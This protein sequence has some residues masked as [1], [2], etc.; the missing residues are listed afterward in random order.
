MASIAQLI[1]YAISRA[2]AREETGGGLHEQ[3]RGFRQV[4]LHDLDNEKF[5]DMYAQTICYGL[6]AAKCNTKQGEPFTR[7]S[8]ARLLPKTN[9]F[10]RK[11]FAH[12]AGPEL[13]ERIVW[14]VE[15]I[16]D[17]LNKTQIWEILKDF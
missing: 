14:A 5:A 12:I 6:Y 16:V 11:M 4:L 17:L 13:D 3:L 1:R 9:P 2:L 8:A 15:D 7:D 10:L